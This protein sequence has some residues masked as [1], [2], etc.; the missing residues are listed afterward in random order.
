VQVEV[1]VAP[2]NISLQQQQVEQEM[3][4]HFVL[5]TCMTGL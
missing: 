4:L 1:M 2:V 5:G 3:L